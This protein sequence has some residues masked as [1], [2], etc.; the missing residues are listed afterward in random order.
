MRTI[1]FILLFCFS[2]VQLYGKQEPALRVAVIGGMTMSGMWQEVAKVF[3]ETYHIPLEVVA[4]G[5][6]H[7]L[8]LYCRTHQVDL[9]TMH[10][11]D[12]MVDLAADGIVENLTPWARNSQMLVG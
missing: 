5:P 6:K 1:I 3:E 2:S 7:E 8:N 10:S 12:T 9:V 4:T 11:S